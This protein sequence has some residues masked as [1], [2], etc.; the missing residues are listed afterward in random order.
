MIEATDRFLDNDKA[1]QWF[2]HNRWPNGVKCPKCN[3]DNIHTKPKKEN[4]PTAYRCRSCRKDF[5][6]KTDTLMHNS[7]LGFRVWALAIYLLTTSLKSV[8]SMKLHRDLKITQKSAWFLAHRIRETYADVKDDVEMFAGPVEID[9]TYVG[10]KEGNKHASDK[11]RQGRGTVGKTAVVGMKDRTTNK[12]KAQVLTTTRKAILQWWVNE[13]AESDA[14]KYTDDNASYDGLDN[15]VSVKHSLN[16]YVRD[17]AHINGIESF[18]SMLKRSHKG[19]F[20]K[21]SPKHLERYVVEFSDKHNTRAYDTI[22]QMA[23]TAQ[24]MSGRSL[25]YRSLIQPNGRSSYAR[26][27]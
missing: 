3:S 24:R 10:G 1:E 25:T 8:S 5:S 7:P 22:D 14:T 23:F 26:P 20:H 4:K 17:M 9:E 13:Y 19:T 2:I 18:W 16:E 12:V 27:S 21:M 15:R 6:V 11:L